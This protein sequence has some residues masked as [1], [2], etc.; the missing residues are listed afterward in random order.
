MMMMMMCQYLVVESECTFLNFDVTNQHNKTPAITLT[1][2]DGDMHKLTIK[3]LE[4]H[5]IY[6]IGN[7]TE[8]KRI[9]KDSVLYA[10][11]GCIMHR[12]WE[13]RTCDESSPGFDTY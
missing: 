3:P 8:N 7:L 12:E 9:L 5:K 6:L 13:H 11:C 10:F 4:Y 2:I 1:R